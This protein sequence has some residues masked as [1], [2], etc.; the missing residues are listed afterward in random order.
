[1][2]L[3][4]GAT[5]ILRLVHLDNLAVYVQRRALHAPNHA[6]DDGL[7][8]R[9]THRVDVQ[10]SR[11]AT[12]VGKGPGGTLLD[13]VPF[14]FGERSPMLFQLHTGWV[15]GHTEGQSAMVYLVA[16]AEGV[17]AGGH[18]FVFYDGH[19]LSKLSQCFD[20][21]GALAALD[22]DTIAARQWK[23]TLA[24][25]DR[26]RRKQAEFLVHRSLPLSQIRG[27]V[28]F[29]EAAKARVAALTA[30]PATTMRNWYF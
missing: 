7:T 14:Y 11:A 8:W 18:G 3:K 23:N 26:Q 5:A 20:D 29:D 24:D 15:E 2:K 19:S 12:P 28:V 1:M 6:P 22:W 13:Y 30:L 27:I 25:P 17:A 9:A 10:T 21:L 4:D 16:A